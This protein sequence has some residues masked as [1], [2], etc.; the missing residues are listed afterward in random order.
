MKAREGLQWA[1]T[2]K[3]GPN[4]VSCVVWALGKLYLYFLRV[5]YILT[6][7]SKCSTYIMKACGGLRWVVKRKMGPNDCLVSFGP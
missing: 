3:T 2:S 7:T 6:T 5:F 4:D 1:V